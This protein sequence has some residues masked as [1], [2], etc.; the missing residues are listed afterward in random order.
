MLQLGPTPQDKR[1]ARDT[2]LGFLAH[3]TDGSLTAGLAQLVIQ[4]GPTPQDQSRVRDTLLGFLADQTDGRLAGQV[5]RAVA[6]LN[7]T[8]EDKRQARGTLLNLLTSGAAAAEILSG[9]VQLDPPVSDLGDW[10]RWALPPT[11]ELLTAARRNSALRDWL[12]A[13]SELPAMPARPSVA[14]PGT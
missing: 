3:A 12:E 9:M 6:Q 11:S 8:D 10:R 1:Q 13:L 7:P 14:W 2:L 4:F 5:A